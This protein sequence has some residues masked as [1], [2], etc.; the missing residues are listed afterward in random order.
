MDIT[1]AE[2]KEDDLLDEEEVSVTISLRIWDVEQ[3]REAAYKRAL[4]DGMN[5]EEAQ[6][7]KDEEKNSL[8]DCAIMLLD[9]G[10]GPAGSE[11][12][13]SSAD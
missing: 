7:F 13:N 3:F 10:C 5:E 8:G 6:E 12:E 1:I 2:S 11:I 9:P 4:E